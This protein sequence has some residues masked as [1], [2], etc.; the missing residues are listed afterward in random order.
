[1][2]HY[3]EIPSASVH[4]FSFLLLSDPP[5]GDGSV[6]APAE[7]T[8]AQCFVLGEFLIQCQHAQSAQDPPPSANWSPASHLTENNVPFPFPKLPVSPGKL[9]RTTGSP[10]SRALVVYSSD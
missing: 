8:T 2:N 6:A 4:Q 7:I 5:S 3:N 1:M 9:T 10:F